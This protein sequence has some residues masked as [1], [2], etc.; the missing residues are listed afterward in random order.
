MGELDVTYTDK[1]G[2]KPHHKVQLKFRG[3]AFEA[4]ADPA[5]TSLFD[6]DNVSQYFVFGCGSKV[7][8]EPVSK[9]HK[10]ISQRKFEEYEDV[11]DL[12]C[13]GFEV[14]DG[15]VRFVKLIRLQV[16]VVT[17]STIA[18]K[19]PH[20]KFANIF[21]VEL[22]VPI[23]TLQLSK[24]GSVATVNAERELNVYDLRGSLL[25]SKQEVGSATFP[26]D[27]SV[28]YVGFSDRISVVRLDGSVDKDV[29]TS[30]DV[31]PELRPV[32]IIFID[33]GNLL[34]TYDVSGKYS[35]LA[36]YQDILECPRYASYI[37][38]VA[39]EDATK[40]SD[41]FIQADDLAE[42]DYAL[43]SVSLP[44]WKL[45]N[46]TKTIVCVASTVSTELV[47]LTDDAL[48][49]PDLDLMQGVIPLDEET[50]DDLPVNGFALDLLSTEALAGVP[51]PELSLKASPRVWVSSV[52]G[53]IVSYEFIHVP[54]MVSGMPQ[55]TAEYQRAQIAPAEKEEVEVSNPFASGDPFGGKKNSV[56]ET[57]PFVGSDPFQKKQGGFDFL[58]GKGEASKS[59][60][61]SGF[62]NSG[63]GNSEAKKSDAENSGFGSSG[64]GTSG[65]GTSGFGTSGFGT[66]GFG[67][68][69]VG[70]S[71]AENKGFGGSGFGKSGFGSSG[72]GTSGFGSA[73]SG[74][75]D[76][77]KS[78]FGQSGFGQSSFGKSG[79]GQSGFGQS[80]FGQSGFGSKAAESTGSFFSQSNSNRSSNNASPFKKLADKEDIASGQEDKAENKPESMFSSKH[81][82]SPFGSLTDKE[83]PFGNLK[84][85][86]K[87]SPFGNLKDKDSESSFGHLKDKD[88]ESPFGHLKNKESESPFGHLKAQDSPFGISKDKD[89]ESPFG[90]LNLNNKSENS[91]SAE[92]KS[93]S[94][95]VNAK[96]NTS[97]SEPEAASSSTGKPTNGLFSEQ[98]SVGAVLNGVESFKIDGDNSKSTSSPDTSISSEGV[99]TP[100]EAE[101]E[102]EEEDDSSSGSE[103]NQEEKEEEKEKPKDPEAPKEAKTPVYA[104]KGISAAKTYSTQSVSTEPKNIKEQGVQGQKKVY[105]NT[106][107]Q[108]FEND[109]EY[110]GKFVTAVAKPQQFTLGKLTVPALSSD[111]LKSHLETL[112]YE[113]EAE[114]VVL[115]KCRESMDEFVRDH[116]QA[117]IEMNKHIGSAIA[118][119]SI[120]RLSD[121]SL[122]LKMSSDYQQKSEATLAALAKISQLVE[123]FKAQDKFLK[124]YDSFVKQ[125]QT[126]ELNNELMRSNGANERALPF[127]VSV[128]NEKIIKKFNS[129]NKLY[130]QIQ[131]SLV[132]LKSQL[133]NADVE[134]TYSKLGTMAHQIG[135]ATRT[136]LLKIS[137]LIK[138]ADSYDTAQEEKTDVGLLAQLDS[139]QEIVK[140]EAR[141]VV[142]DGFKN[143]PLD[144][145]SLVI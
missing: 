36:E 20:N 126:V 123:E 125:F 80:G 27:G 64:F 67:K 100:S 144:S 68:S 119:S 77:G 32:S 89:L 18:L 8:Y 115:E 2:F 73:Q 74:K 139:E 116:L 51:N 65:F 25:F 55:I 56:F 121:A 57:K 4:A 95:T 42:R 44:N 138:E 35:D 63:F 133:Q 5:V 102:A 14:N 104:E 79:F 61:G 70:K 81:S 31:A 103:E 46:A 11:I 15:P 88:S 38:N 45:G 59:D 117:K 94:E 142:L 82:D 96:A 49:R 136:Q 118:N 97:P 54:S 71:D 109:V 101:E 105:V 85:K 29:Y 98:D 10:A 107:L 129:V 130:Y 90:N 91:P 92:S 34:V 93:L 86:N 53:M 41:E 22:S 124:D 99:E 143:A 83:S 52:G 50:Y 128:L 134:Q 58:A 76:F 30:K 78:S 141:L 39:S 122:L 127:E 75:S 69:E 19:D 87:E 135:E 21:S 23:V 84:D 12:D 3:A 72:F 6:F 13:T 113:S 120:W 1:F 114:Y 137:Q 37:V 111:S 62:G 48:Y 33:E 43:Y 24:N 140:L 132:E 40:V 17:S 108:T 66:S 145:L 9:L 47:L 26:E 60:A 16:L 110:L 28:V 131:N 7:V 112:Y 106:G